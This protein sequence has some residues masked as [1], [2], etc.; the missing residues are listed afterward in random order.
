MTTLRI[1]ENPFAQ[2]LGVKEWQERVF[3]Q[4]KPEEYLVA[5]LIPANSLVSLQTNG[6]YGK[7]TLAVQ[8]AMTIAFDVPFLGTHPCLQPGKVLFLNARD[9]DEDNHGR[10]KRLVREWSK[11][12]PDLNERIDENVNNL[13]CVSMF[14]DCYGVTPHLVDGSGSSTRT[15]TY[16][17]Q[18]SDYFKTKLIVLDPVEDFFRVGDVPGAAD[19]LHLVTMAQHVLHILVR[20][21]E[22]RKTFSFTNDAPLP[23]IIAVEPSVVARLGQVAGLLGLIDVAE[24]M[25]AIERVAV[26]HRVV[27][28][29]LGDLLQEPFGF[30]RGAQHPVILEDPP[31]FIFILDILGQGHLVTELGQ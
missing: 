13:T 20:H 1:E 3:T 27:F 5:D 24:A 26:D 12:V 17:Y 11:S 9:T 4:P 15:Y 14:D 28:P 8:L 16:L 18:F 6:V 19:T 21:R 31:V 10:F 7:T 25:K 2:K 29:G 22:R 23:V 30:F